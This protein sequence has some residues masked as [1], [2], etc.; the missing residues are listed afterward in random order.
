MFG[1]TGG[2]IWIDGYELEA[3]SFDGDPESM[4]S[5]CAP[6]CDGRPVGVSIFF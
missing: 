2:S 5:V 1:L 4:T 6:A 3:S